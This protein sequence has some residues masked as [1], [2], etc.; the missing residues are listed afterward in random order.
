MNHAVLLYGYDSNGNWLIKNQWGTD[1]GNQGF[2]TLSSTNDCG[3]STMLGNIK[4][5]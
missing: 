2:M 4:F 5:S 3:M 1:W